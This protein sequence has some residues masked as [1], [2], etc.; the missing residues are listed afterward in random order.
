MNADARARTPAHDGSSVRDPPVRRALSA[1]IARTFVRGSPL[2]PEDAQPRRHQ[3]EAERRDHHEGLR[4]RRGPPQAARGEVGRER[5]AQTHDDLPHADHG[6]L[7]R[8]SSRTVVPSGS[9][10]IELVP[11]TAATR[12]KI[13]AADA[14]PV[15]RHA[16]EV[17]AGPRVADGDLHVRRIGAAVDAHRESGAAGVLRGVRDRLRRGQH[18]RA[19]DRDPASTAS[20]VRSHAGRAHRHR[21]RVP[22]VRCRRRG[23]RH[24]SARR[25]PLRSP[26]RCWPAG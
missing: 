22:P 19:R 4:H 26:A 18:E 12:A 1:T 25:C 24:P 5:Q 20:A 7:S 16:V 10:S 14:E 8:H 21:V 17:E 3:V 23:S 13:D 9:E 15:V 2:L 11:P 6:V